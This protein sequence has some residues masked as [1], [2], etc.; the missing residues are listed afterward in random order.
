MTAEL[1]SKLQDL[2]ADVCACEA[3]DTAR[4]RDALDTLRLTLEN[5][6]DYGADGATLVYARARLVDAILIR[7][8]HLHLGTYADQLSLIAVGGY[9][10]G[11]LHPG[12]D[13]DIC[14]LV[15][16]GTFDE[17]ALSRYL[18]SLWDI[19]LDIGSSVRSLADSHTQAAADITV[20][21][22]LLESR[23][24]AGDTQLFYE[25]G[26]MLQSPDL[27]PSEPFFR[28]KFEEQQ[29]R[30]SKYFDSAGRLEP[31]VKESPGGL[32]DLQTIRWIAVRHFGGE[33]L[34]E[35]VFHRLLTA[36][37]VNSLRECREFL[38]RVRFALHRLTG[39]G[40]DRLLFDHQRHLATAFNA[41]GES[42]NVA[43]EQFM[44]QYY[45]VVTQVTRLNEMLLQMFREEFINAQAGTVE[46]IDTRF[47]IQNGYI[48]ARDD[49]V[50]TRYPPAL[51][52]I[53]T[54]GAR[55]ANIK[56]IRAGTV[57]LIQEN[58]HIIDES[59]R[60]ELQARHA[61]ID[62]FRQ[63]HG[64]THQLDRMNR[65][66]VL[67]AYLPNFERIVG[68]MQFD[69][70][71]IYTVDQHTLMVVR[72][73]RQFAVTEHA[74]TH[75]LCS[76]VFNE[77]PKPYVLYL[78]GLFHDIA[79]GRGGAHEELG[80]VDTQEFCEQHGLPPDDTELAVWGVRN[81]LLMSL[82]AQRRDIHD[83]EVVHDF[84][85]EIGDLNRLN[86]LFLLTV[87]DIC[88]TDPSLWTDWK[89]KLI[90]QLYRA[91]RNALECGLTA[92]PDTQEVVATRHQEALAFAQRTAGTDES[93]RLERLKAL[94][95]EDYFLR[96]TPDEIAWHA[97]IL[98]RDGAGSEEQIFIRHIKESTEIA[99]YTADHS[100]LF[101]NLTGLLCRENLDV[102]DAR[103]LT[104]DSG[105]AF[106]VFH[107]VDQSGQSLDEA[108]AELVR[109]SLTHHRK[110]IESVAPNLAT[111]KLR[112]FSL[113]PTVTF[114]TEGSRQTTSVLI[115]ATDHPGLLYQIGRSFVQHNL[116]LHD[117][118][119]ATFGEKA[120]DVFYITDHEGEPIS[121]QGTLDALRET[122]IHNLSNEL[123]L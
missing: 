96:F 83:P 18:T 86:H 104:T 29:E 82:V 113:K 24:L 85:A 52:E 25:L 19:G 98:G 64:L 34:D 46:I 55:H 95:G 100:M 112:A 6:F 63:P 71:H 76:E 44:Q 102:L 65:L 68:L 90:T 39:R 50:F 47:Q 87:A 92:A 26:E 75:P 66:G 101:A 49:D 70:F 114:D 121:D 28:A 7:L 78:M 21:T 103:V 13:V 45:R 111:R 40:D 80:A 3:V 77:I 54:I 41:S 99:V 84:A 16:D 94:L 23:Q 119:V 4:W 15:P 69:M 107:V 12:S 11:E 31:N 37:E 122:I 36:E 60:S 61:F 35:L 106:D 59:F 81:H 57:R 10:R 91:T 33:A 1:D 48:E 115:T 2:I 73:L 58:L 27:W 20:M 79:K 117:A 30:R 118:K 88:G 14:V 108:T 17:N 97:K 5:A 62:L 120:E 116:I 72:N 43:V 38:W 93:I 9:G 109:Q 51:L 67:A 42:E 8:W 22:N 56:G 89:N 110:P 32:R 105:F 74:H 53:F 123:R